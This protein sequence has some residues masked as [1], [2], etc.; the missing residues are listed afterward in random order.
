MDVCNG[1]NGD[2]MGPLA[3]LSLFPVKS[4]NKWVEIEKIN[5]QTVGVRADCDQNRDR[6]LRLTKFAIFVV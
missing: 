3:C 4:V 1:R 5:G 6:C 2:R